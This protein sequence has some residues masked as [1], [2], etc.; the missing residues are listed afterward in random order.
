MTA[1][2]QLNLPDEFLL[3]DYNAGSIANVPATVAALLD[4]PFVGLPPLHDELWRPLTGVKR[5]VVLLVDAW[6][7]NL[8]EQERQNLAG[9]LGRTAVSATVTSIFPSTTVAALSSVWTGAAPAQH[10]FVGF[11][12]FMP[13]YAV[14]TQMIHFTPTFGKYPDALIDAGLD[15]Q[16]FLAVPGF[17]EQLTA[18]GV[19]SYAFKGREIVDSALSKMHDRGVTADYGASSLADMF[20]QIR[21]LLEAKAGEKLFVNAYWP[22]VDTLSHIYGWNQEPVA[23]E[24]RAIMMLLE[25]ELFNKLSP[26]ARRDT[27]VFIMADHGQVVTPKAQRV[28]LDEHPRLQEML[29][30]RPSGEPRTAYLYAKHGR[31]ADIVQY[32][33][34][35]LGHAMV[36]LPA[37]AALAAGLLGPLPHAAQTAERVGDVIVTM[38]EGYVLLTPP[39]R[40]NADKMQGRHGGMTD[41]EMRVPWLGFRLDE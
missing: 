12:L 17:A 19:S 39:E 26:A 21:Q 4:V 2:H 36:A 35:E 9:L 18:A 7:W 22:V 25:A 16:T 24:L 37:E 31:Q 23:A 3:P 20:V 32:I 29:L 40:E 6:G 27:A 10:G 5:V 13:D 15:P 8:L 11:R 34:E 1:S 41:A 38:R 33:N 14:L 28:H 30:M